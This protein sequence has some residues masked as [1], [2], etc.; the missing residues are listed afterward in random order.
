MEKD[1]ICVFGDDL[2]DL[3][4]IRAFPE[5]VAMGNGAEEVKMAAK[6]I[7]PANDEDGI[8]QAIQMLGLI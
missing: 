8:A 4:M 7:A 2:N 1:E 5:S 6:Y 3:E